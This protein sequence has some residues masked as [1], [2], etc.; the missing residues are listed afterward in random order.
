MILFHYA[1]PNKPI[2]NG[3]YWFDYGGKLRDDV[4][5]FLYPMEYVPTWDP[6]YICCVDNMQDLLTYFPQH[7]H[8]RLNGLYGIYVYTG[9][10]IVQRDTVMEY[11]TA[12]ANKLKLL[13]Q[14]DYAGAQGLK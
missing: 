6:D 2:I 13:D 14:L 1:D 10:L 8:N 11:V 4:P 12:D 5:D 3:G 9:K 7:I